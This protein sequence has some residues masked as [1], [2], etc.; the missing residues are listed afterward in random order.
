MINF[1]YCS[2]LNK[3]STPFL[4]YTLKLI[5]INTLL[6][7]NFNCYKLIQAYTSIVHNYG[8]LDKIIHETRRERKWHCISYFCAVL[9]RFAIRRCG[10]ASA[11]GIIKT[12]Q[13]GKIFFSRE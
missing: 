11:R 8:T 10:K 4:L 5:I 1:V 6:F 3:L 7:H 2:F 9:L 12:K 13:Q